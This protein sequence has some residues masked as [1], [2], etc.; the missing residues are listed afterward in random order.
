LEVSSTPIVDE[1]GKINYAIAT[2]VDITD[3]K[4]AEKLLADYNRTLEQ[5]V[6]D[7]TFELQREII[8]RK[9]A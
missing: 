2:F 1:T 9:R 4:Q 8:D 5:Q 6:S 7:R 3:R